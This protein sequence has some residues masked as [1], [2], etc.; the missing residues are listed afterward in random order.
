MPGEGAGHPLPHAFGDVV[1]DEVNVG[2]GAAFQQVVVAGQQPINQFVFQG[3]GAV[4]GFAG[5]DLGDIDRGAIG[6]PPG[7]EVRSGW[8]G[9][10]SRTRGWRIRASSAFPPR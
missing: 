10:S 9:K 5:G 2:F 3:A 6:S 1:A 8:R 4:P 7:P